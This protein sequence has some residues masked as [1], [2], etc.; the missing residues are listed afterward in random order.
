MA[1][2]QKGMNV[3][4]NVNQ[5][6]N[7]LFGGNLLKNGNEMTVQ[8][9]IAQKRQ[10]YLKQANKAVKEADKGERK[11]DKSIE[12]ARGQVKECFD[13]MD[14]YGKKMKDVDERLAQLKE[15]FGVADDSQE[16][17]DLEIL[18]KIQEGLSGVSGGALTEEEIE[19]LKDMGEPTEYQQEALNLLKEKNYYS[20]ERI[21]QESKIVGLGKGI[22]QAKTDRLASHG[23]IDAQKSKEE[24]IE[25]AS[26]EIFGMLVEDAKDKIDEKAEEI[27]EA[28]EKREEKKEEM[29]ER[30]EAVK[31]DKEQKEAAVEAAQEAAQEMTK[32]MAKSDDLS[33]E[34]DAEVKKMEALQKQLE[35]DLKGIMVDKIV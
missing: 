19:R 13:L 34:V 18:V 3:N 22:R 1:R 15:Q 31:E 7:T 27:Q 20:M 28:A 30:L 21:K 29:E 16:Q 8:E 5:E 10:L 12:D 26:K 6:R 4:L 25:A 17:K 24:L 33:A 23:M 2:R 9:R 14:E 11:M 32:Q 35:E